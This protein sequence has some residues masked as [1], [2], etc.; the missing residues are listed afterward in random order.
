MKSLIVLLLLCPIFTLAQ[1]ESSKITIDDRL[2]EVFDENYLIQLQ[3]QNPFLIQRW[4]Y[5]LDHAFYIVEDP[6]L[7]E[8][9]Y[10]SVK[11]EDIRSFNILQIERE[12]DLKR[13]FNQESTYHIEGTN[14]ALI[15]YPA[16]VFNKHLNQHLGRIPKE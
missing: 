10:P 14:K 13:H 3:K 6:K 11:I 12:Q 7:S 5:Y 2:Y 8:Y 1:N 9:E 4:T 15:Y 16:K